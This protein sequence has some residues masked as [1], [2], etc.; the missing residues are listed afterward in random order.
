ML[1]RK[2]SSVQRGGGRSPH[3]PS[4]RSVTGGN[5]L[6]NYIYSDWFS[7][8]LEKKFISHEWREV[9]SDLIVLVL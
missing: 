8:A 1:V 2:S 9:D 6:T 3:R 7:L 4:L 5:F